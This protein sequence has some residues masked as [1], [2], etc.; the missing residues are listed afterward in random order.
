MA[1]YKFRI[2][3][4]AQHRML[5]LKLVDPATHLAVAGAPTVALQLDPLRHATPVDAGDTIQCKLRRVHFTDPQ[6]GLKKRCYALATIPEDDE[7][8]DGNSDPAADLYLGG[9]AAPGG[10]L[11][12]C[13]ITELFGAVNYFGVKRYDGTSQSGSQFLVAKSI[14]SRPTTGEF[15][16]TL[17]DDN[18]RS[19]YNGSTYET[20]VM[21]QPFAVVGIVWG[22]AVDHSGVTVSG[23][24][25]LFLEVNTEREWTTPDA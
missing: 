19:S 11:M 7:S 17:S 22:S 4:D 5:I 18:N 15:A 21:M 13:Q 6:D 25:V 24:E 9:G 14:P 20:Q 16:Y 12:M 10:A 23:S 8:E 2:E 3:Q 1:N